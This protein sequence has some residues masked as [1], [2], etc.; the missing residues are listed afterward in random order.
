M[1]LV[2]AFTENNH[3]VK[4]NIQGTH[5]D[6]LFQANQI[7]ELLEI[8]EIRS[9]VRDFDDDEK[10]VHTVHTPGGA[11]EVL[12][13]T[14]IGLYR[15][16]GM[17]RKPLARPFQKWVAKTIK[18]IRL[19]G[20]Y[21]LERTLNEERDKG[22]R[23]REAQ[24]LS[25]EKA[26][27]LQ[28]KLAGK[29]APGQQIY[30]LRNPA[31]ANRNLYKLGRTKDLSKRIGNYGTSMPDGCTIM[32]TLNC[33][34]AIACERTVGKALEKYI[35]NREWYQCD[36]S[37]IVH[38]METAV[39]ACDGMVRNVDY[40]EK[41]DIKGK[42]TA[43]FKNVENS[44][45]WELAGGLPIE[46]RPPSPEPRRGI[47]DW[48]ARRL[49]SP[50]PNAQATKEIKA[51]N[52]RIEFPHKTQAALE[53]QREENNPFDVWLND[54]LIPASGTRMHFHRLEREYNKTNN[55]EKIRPALVTRKLKARGIDISPVGKNCP[56][57]PCCTSITR[58]ISNYSLA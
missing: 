31:D 48:F 10:G 8:E 19:T 49:R 35:Y 24:R 56:D 45:R 39:C 18:E 21:E 58:Y 33:I 34:D 16:L 15:L 14:E 28:A 13:L 11:Q 26:I 1:D 42:V 57:L 27:Q 5:D 36:L 17:S 43:M 20:K 29:Y 6:P 47:I 2:K 32:H 53:E 44:E 7:G 46:S 25:E 55:T 38:A 51:E 40:L 30:V 50:E 23:A 9:S 3:T 4:V 41:Y 52:G 22:N 37:I 12:F 54:N